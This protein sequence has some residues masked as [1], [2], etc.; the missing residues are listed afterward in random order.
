MT[1]TGLPKQPWDLDSPSPCPCPSHHY[2]GTPSQVSGIITHILDDVAAF[3][4]AASNNMMLQACDAAKA[5]T[6]VKP[7]STAISNISPDSHFLLQTRCKPLG[8][9]MDLALAQFSSPSPAPT[10]PC[11]LT[12]LSPYRAPRRPPEVPLPA[13][14]LATLLHHLRH[15]P[16]LQPRPRYCA[17][18]SLKLWKRR[19]VGTP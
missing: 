2:S 14:H 11:S 7:Y 16:A 13:L 9:R 4:P 3:M 17:L 1:T 10:R 18:H 15:L 8:S 19:A 5:R 6:R 12:A